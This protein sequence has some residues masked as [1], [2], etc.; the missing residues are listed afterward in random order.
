[1]CTLIVAWRRFE[2]APV[3]VA[4]NRDEATDRP[5]SPPQLRDGDPAVLAPRDLRAGGTW[6]GHN[7]EGVF[8]GVT[9]RWMPGEGE[10]SRGLLVDDALGALSAAAAIETVDSELR[11]REY[12]PFHLLAA[13]GH[14]CLLVSHDEGGDEIR[15]LAPGVHVV[16]NVGFDGEWFRPEGRPDAGATQAANAERVRATLTPE[17]GETAAAWTD[18]AGAIL[19]DHEHGVCIHREGFGTRS[20]A[21]IRLGA[22]RAFEYADGPPCEAAF[23]PVGADL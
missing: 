5:S 18:R 20:S 1:M 12:A 21:L 22:D 16:V 23:R 15:S 3:C 8:V 17:A 9:N 19:G 13:D 2:E 10:R 11:T 14:D 7:D 6:L 4:A